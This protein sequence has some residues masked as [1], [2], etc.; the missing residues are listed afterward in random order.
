VLSAR[1]GSQSFVHPEGVYDDPNG[2]ALR[3][4][5]YRRL[6]FR[7][8]FQN[9]KELFVGTNDHGRMRFG[10]SIY[11]TR[12]STRRFFSASNLF[13]PSTIDESFRHDG[14]GPLAGIKDSEN[15]WNIAGHKH[16][17]IEVD[18]EALALFAQLYDAPG[19]PALEARLPALHARELVAVLR[20]FAAYPKRLGDLEGQYHTTEMWH[21]TNSVIDGT[22]RRDTGFPT[23]AREW[24]LSGPHFSIATP[25]TKTPRAV[26]TA[27]GHYDPL[28]LTELPP[29]Y[30]P[31]TNYK[32]ACDEDEYFSR[33]PVVPWGEQKPVT[34][35]Y[36]LVSR[37]ALS[38]SGER[39][40]L[41]T[42]FPPGI[43]HI[44]GCFSLTFKN[45][46]DMLASCVG[47]A[48]LPFDYLVKSTGKADFRGDLA[49]RLP[50][51][52]HSGQLKSRI[53]LLN[54][55]TLHYSDLWRTCFDAAFTRDAWTK[56]D[57]R[58]CNSRFSNLTTEWRWSTPLR[59]DYERRQALIEIDVLA[60]RALGLT[61]EELRTIYRIQFPVLQQYER[62]TYY[63][64]NGRIVYL[65]GDRA[66]GFSTPEWKDRKEK[67]HG[68]VTRTITDDTLPGGPRERVITYVAPFDAC[69]RETDYAT[70]WAEFDRR[71][72]GA[73]ANAA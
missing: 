21:E 63:D 50:L 67:A 14:R 66:Y 29:D 17:I 5:I 35:F 31:R 13:W 26:C 44:D 69:D 40:L 51:L 2:G 49:T 22:I 1:D 48:S 11:G 37:R 10:T 53:L 46:A 23:D 12:T 55:L 8:Q 61:L 28:D 71:E 9:E 34:D 4:E 60:A 47:Y 52:S 43:G 38:Q 45:T 41:A 6:R 7:F 62:N 32:P 70:A 42:I 33:T 64:R 59:T 36:R 18:E 25:F 16:R 3:S 20:K 27:N 54:C 56:S 19:T 65:D 68:T 73:I 24:V 72:R 39:T 30:L 15:N 58:L 57:P